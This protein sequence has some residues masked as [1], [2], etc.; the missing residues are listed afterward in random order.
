MK[1]IGIG[2]GAKQ[3]LS[4]GA[5]E[6]IQSA[7]QLVLQTGSIPLADW[8]REQGVRFETLDAFYEQAED[9]EELLALALAHLRQMPGATLCLMGEL[10]Q[11]KLA[12]AL[13]AEGLAG[14]ILPGVGFGQAALDLCAG[15]VCPAGAFLCPASEFEQSGF[16]GGSSLV[17]TELDSPYLAA[18]LFSALARFYPAD[19]PCHLVH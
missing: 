16:T 10:S 6:Q 9:F 19:A 17:L 4:L 13:A 5:W 14:E 2:I 8:L 18:E 12:A 11:H 15:A 3:S 1:I 7:E